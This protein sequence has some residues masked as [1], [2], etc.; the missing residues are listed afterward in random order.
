MH[1]TRMCESEIVRLA[2]KVS[3]DCV[4]RGAAGANKAREIK[5]MKVKKT[6][7]MYFLATLSQKCG[8]LSADSCCGI[9]LF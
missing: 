2:Q 7:C 8:R 5:I 4:G 6:V 1:K 3:P 9:S